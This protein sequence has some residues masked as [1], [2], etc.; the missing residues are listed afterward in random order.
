MLRDSDAGFLRIGL[1]QIEIFFRAVRREDKFVLVDGTP[2]NHHHGHV[3]NR[4]GC[5]RKQPA[6]NVPLK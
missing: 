4:N 6:V 1:C 5:R 3:W 2:V